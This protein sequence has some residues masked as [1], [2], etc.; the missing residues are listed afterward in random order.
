MINTLTN[1]QVRLF[2]G[3]VYKTKVSKSNPEVSRAVEKGTPKI[4]NVVAVVIMKSILAFNPLDAPSS[5]FK[6]SI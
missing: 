2:L 3:K 5:A 4:T 6:I 1:Y